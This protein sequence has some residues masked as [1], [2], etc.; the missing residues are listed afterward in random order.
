M[1]I[2]AD[3]MSSENDEGIDNGE[4]EVGVDEAEDELGRGEIKPDG[5]IGVAESSSCSP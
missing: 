5:F 1:L 2:A 3:G 4:G